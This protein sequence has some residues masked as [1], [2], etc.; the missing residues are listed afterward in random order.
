MENIYNKGRGEAMKE[1][2]IGMKIIEKRR[3][4]GL[5]QEELADYLGIS[6]PA[7]SKW[8]SGQ[9]YPDITLLPVIASYFDIS[10]DELFDYQ[11]QMNKLEIRK[12]YRKLSQRFTEVGFEEAHQEWSGYVKKY[13]SCWPLLMNM[14][15]LLLNQANL[16]SSPVRQ[17]EVLNE[18]IHLFERIETCADDPKLIHQI[19]ML[20]ATAHLM[21]GHA[22]EVIDLLEDT[23]EILMSTDIPLASAYMMKQENE[24]AIG[25]LQGS[26]FLSV[27][28]ILSAYP[29]LMNLY[30]DDAAAMDR[31]VASG[32]KLI[33]AYGMDKGHPAT[34]LPF[35]LATA[36]IYLGN[37]REE[38]AL[39]HLEAYARIV[40]SPGMLPILLR[41]TPLFDKIDGLIESLDL[42]NAA[43]RSDDAVK[44]SIKDVILK[45]PAFKS[46]AENDRFKRIVR[47]IEAL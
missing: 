9:S 36:A 35:H 34:V 23:Q 19:P 3:E 29:T 44:Q 22:S 27:I 5:T 13:Y 37:G 10:V 1:I 41:G 18:V 25:L 33:E 30:K 21:M 28:S 12:L 26:V 40:C 46:L 16:A 39:A 47:D 38:Q 4:K 17:E 11:P 32:S 20:K 31:W 42:G 2:R 15:I 45:H 8:E 14:G 7:V 6:K 43:P 24:K